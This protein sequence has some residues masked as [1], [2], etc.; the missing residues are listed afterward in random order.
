MLTGRPPFTGTTPLSTLEQVSSQEPLSPSKLQRHTPRDLEIICLKCLEKEPRR[1]YATALELAEDLR[2]F[3]A[4]EPILARPT[5]GWERAWKWAR[6]RPITATAAACVVGSVLVLLG[7]ALYYN[8][9]LYRAVQAARTAERSADVSADVAREQRNIALKALKRIIYDVEEKLN[10]TPATRTLREGLLN[11]AIADLEAIAQS[12]LGSPPDLS[13]ADAHEKLGDIYRIIGHDVEARG[14]YERSRRL[15]E[16]LLRSESAGPQAADA[17]YRTLMGLGLLD[18]ALEQFEAAKVE[19]QHAV[20]VAEEIAKRPQRPDFR[21][22]LIE[23]YLQLGRAYS[24]AHEVRESEVCFRKMQDLAA[25][26]VSLEPKNAQ[27]RDLLAS[28][29]RK[30]GDLRKFEKNFQ[31]AREDYLRAIKI[32]E[33]LLEQWPESFPYKTHLAIAIDDL[34]GVA[35]DQGEIAE[36]RQRF[37][38]SKRL[39]S[40]LLRSD[41]DNVETRFWLIHIQLHL[42]RLEAD[43]S[44][45]G[46]AAE[47]YRT[48]LDQVNRL[49]NDGR[50]EGRHDPNVN[51]RVVATELAV[52]EAAPRALEDVSYAVAQP[53]VVAARLLLLRATRPAHASKDSRRLAEAGESLL[54]LDSKDPIDQHDLARQIAAFLTALEAAPWP[55]A[56]QSR[57]EALRGRC[58][59][60][61]VA[62]LVQ[63]ADGG[64]ARAVQT[65]SALLSPLKHHPGYQALINRLQRSPVPLDRRFSTSE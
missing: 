47:L 20:N 60:R 25:H 10:Q 34:A 17:L 15:A 5:P 52:V 56:D 61:A 44:R 63:S 42:A 46:A 64:A 62:L 55:T 49:K 16:G 22:G 19:F 21:P 48:A 11:S 39:F 23:A 33:A 57:R 30:L 3:Q 1:R 14:H 6:R 7:G 27:A 51:P 35:R 4:G 36:A 2:R 8:A 9:R 37:S 50:L 54:E 24:F 18:I 28:S 13:Q 38:A 41:P 59:D 40:E 26:W 45:F 12:T 32:G 29:Y 31:A 53:A 65:E 43:Q 58:A